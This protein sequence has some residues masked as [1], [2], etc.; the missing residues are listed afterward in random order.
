[1]VENEGDRWTCLMT[2]MA[3]TYKR[4][5]GYAVSDRVVQQMPVLASICGAVRY[6]HESKQARP[7]RSTVTAAV[8]LTGQVKRT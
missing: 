2:M 7:S 8:R 3:L 4:F 6:K 5:H 1:M